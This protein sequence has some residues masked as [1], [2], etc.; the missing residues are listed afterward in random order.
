M[1]SIIVPIYNVESYLVECLE[2][3]LLQTVLEKEIILVDDGSTDGSLAICQDYA[4]RYGNIKLISQTNQ[5]QSVA[6]NVGMD[7]AQGDYICFMD[8]DDYLTEPEALEQ[9]LNRLQIEQADIVIFGYDVVY[10]TK[11]TSSSLTPEVI[12]RKTAIYYQVT[13]RLSG[14]VWARLFRREVLEGCR[15]PVGRIAEDNLFSYQAF[16]K[17]QRIVLMTERY[18]AHRRWSGSTTQRMDLPLLDFF[19]LKAEVF[20]RAVVRYPELSRYELA[21]LVPTVINLKN[22]VQADGGVATALR[23][24]VDEQFYAYFPSLLWNRDV[25]FRTKVNAV[26][27]VFNLSNTVRKLVMK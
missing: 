2:S 6:R 11:T 14:M 10:P 27:T 1:I 25:R 23:K 15:F 5:G 18:Y 24:A 12:D 17:S 20:R 21:Y 13:N 4:N 7:C 22:R 8:S 16:E 26:L 3:L 9:A 19:E